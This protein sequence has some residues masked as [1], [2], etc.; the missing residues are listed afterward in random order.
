MERIDPSSCR[1]T[2]MMTKR[3]MIG[4]GG[5]VF[6]RWPL[7]GLIGVLVCT[8]AVALV[9]AELPRPASLGDCVALALDRNDAIRDARHRLEAARADVAASGRL[10]DPTVRID[11]YLEQVETRV[12]AQRAR[13]SAQQGIPWPGRLMAERRV[14]EE[15][16]AVAAAAVE[17]LRSVVG[18]QVTTLVAEIRYLSA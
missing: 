9:A 13:L 5:P 17:Q 11:S 7:S 10:P 3:G 6:L 16:E 18:A 4:P 12:G 2:T 15:Q 1:M 14:A 8:G